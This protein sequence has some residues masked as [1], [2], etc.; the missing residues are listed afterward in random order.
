MAT[1]GK[2]NSFLIGRIYERTEALP[3]I[4]KDIDEIKQKQTN[5]FY[6]I[7]GL[8]KRV[9]KIESTSLSCLTRKAGRMIVSIIMGRLTK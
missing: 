3:Q 9:R 5:D 4:Q 7:K 6:E 1:N 8:K 2:S